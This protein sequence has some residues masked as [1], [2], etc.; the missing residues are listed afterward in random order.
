L[1]EVVIH[2]PGLRNE[3]EKPVLFFPELFVCRNRGKTEF[4]VPK[5][6]LAL[7]AKSDATA[8]G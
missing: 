6:T 1:A 3:G 2:F 7:L 5:D 4:T 8:N